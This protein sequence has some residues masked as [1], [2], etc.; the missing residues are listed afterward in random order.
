MSADVPINES[1]FEDTVCIQRRVIVENL[2]K[3]EGKSFIIHMNCHYYIFCENILPYKS[4]KN[5]NS[6]V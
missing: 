3:N 6:R 4:G 2:H 1:F 5:V